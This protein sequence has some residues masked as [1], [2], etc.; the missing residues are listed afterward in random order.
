MPT[1]G[2]APA[3]RPLVLA[4]G[5]MLVGLLHL[6]LRVGGSAC[7]AVVVRVRALAAAMVPVY[8]DGSRDGRT[9]LEPVCVRLG[10]VVQFDYVCT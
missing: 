1:A 8:T 4:Q 6:G 7:V 2:T 10:R 5:S 9:V 3:E